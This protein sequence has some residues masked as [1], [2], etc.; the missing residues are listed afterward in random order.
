MSEKEVGQEGVEVWRAEVPD[1][2]IARKRDASTGWPRVKAKEY[3]VFSDAVLDRTGMHDYV[4]L[5]MCEPKVRATVSVLKQA[6][7]APIAGVFKKWYPLL[8]TRLMQEAT[9]RNLRIE[10]N[11]K[12]GG[13]VYARDDR[14]HELLRDVYF[15]QFLAGDFSAVEDTYTLLNVRLQ[16]EKKTKVRRVPV[17]T[18]EGT[19]KHVDIV[20]DLKQSSLGGDLFS[21]RA[22]GVYNPN[23]TN[24]YKQVVDNTLHDAILRYPPFHHDMYKLNRDGFLFNGHVVAIDVKHF[25]RCVGA[26]VQMR[27]DMIGAGYGSVQHRIQSQP[28]LSVAEDWQTKYFIKPKSGYV[29]QLASGDSSVATLGKET[30]IVLYAEYF[31]S[32]WK[33]DADKA[34]DLALNGGDPSRVA[35]FNYGDDNV[36]YGDRKKELDNMQK[37]LSQYLTIE[38]EEP[39]AF[40]GWEYSTET[41]FFLRDRSAIVNFWKP[42]R[43]PGPPFRPF[44]FLGFYLRWKTY[45]QYGSKNVVRLEEEMWDVMNDF[46]ITED[47]M[48]MWVEH[49]ITQAGAGGMP[50]NYITGKTYLL[51]DEEKELLGQSKSIG[52][53]LSREIFNKLV[54]ARFRKVN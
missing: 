40:L 28:Y 10:V 37:F 23:I 30:L 5:T 20:G 50:L 21:A 14:K 15:P 38:V 33:V 1:N 49:E 9:I 27:A 43:P 13:P 19:Y 51:T 24:S 7:M 53:G 32:F 48:R 36:L 45:R 29:A 11:S 41:G 12:M 17:I 34:I 44:F 52:L 39:T 42:E 22:R 16:Q 4:G 3:Q 47:Y 46:G 35:F 6:D 2:H 8:L 54:D 26:L 31:S 25:E 18:S